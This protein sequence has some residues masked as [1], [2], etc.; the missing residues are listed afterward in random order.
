MPAVARVWTCRL[1]VRGNWAALVSP[2]RTATQS[3]RSS[4]GQAPRSCTEHPRRP[5]TY[6][7]TRNA[8]PLWVTQI[9]AGPA[10][11]RI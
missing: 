6:P 1:P 3:R 7:D 11:L 9:R 4:H 2:A 8:H 10:K 5:S